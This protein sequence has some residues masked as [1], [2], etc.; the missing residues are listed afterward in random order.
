MNVLDLFSGIGG[1]SLGLERAGFKT[2]GF[3]E[4]E[5]YARAVL[6]KHWPTV[7]CHGDITQL[8]GSQYAGTIDVVCG[9]YPCQPF[10]V[11][12]KQKGANDPRHLWPEMLRVIQSV[13]PRWVIA[14]N[15]AGHIRLGFDEVAA[16]LEAENFTVW[17]F[18]VP[19]C[20]VDAPHR[21]ERLWIVANRQCEG[22][23]RHTWNG[24]SSTGRKEQD[25]PISQSSLRSN[26]ADASCSLPYGCGSAGE[27]RRAEFANCGQWETEPSIC[28]V[29]DGLPNR[30]HRL[31]ALGNSIVPQIAQIIGQAIME[32]ENARAN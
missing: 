27:T 8:D 18:L 6:A 32:Y 29:V 23:E 14:E 4:I 22:L 20:A 7:P 1:F 15:V 17:P 24:A 25:G 28:R 13:R 21:R 19:A 9:G 12:G 2:I 30:S 26:V 10:S 16:S 11:A 5:P 3:C 31:R